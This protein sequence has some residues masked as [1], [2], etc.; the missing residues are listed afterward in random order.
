MDKK[1]A[2]PRPLILITNDDGYQAQGIGELATLMRELGDV[3]VVAPDAARSGAGCSITSTQPVSLQL[4]RRETSDHA[5]GCE[6]WACSGLPVDCVK[7][8]C[9][10]VCPR[11]PDLVV[12]G[13]NHGDNASCSVHY[14][15]TMGA[16]FEACLKGIPA[17]G[18]SLRTLKHECDFAPYR[19]AVLRVATNVLT[20]GLPHGTCL[21]VN[22]PE[23]PKL[24][25]IRVCRMA[26]GEWMKE[27]AE[28]PCPRGG[29]WFWLTGEFNFL[30]PEAD[31]TDYWALDHDYAAVVPVKMDLTD[32]T[33]LP[34]LEA[35]FTE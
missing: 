16:V 3:V 20:D 5:H 29:R 4:V 7:L 34:R 22:F 24:R 18:F 2:T 23:V 28:V 12:S 25:G 30:E 9:E 8:A 27:W 1:T 15:G 33:L 10:A 14:S 32:Y 19:K 31:D 13:I 6:V 17:I 35:A 21:N 26:R 11:R